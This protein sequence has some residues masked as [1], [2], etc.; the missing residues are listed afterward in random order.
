MSGIRGTFWADESDAG[1]CEVPHGNYHITN[2]V[3]LGQQKKL[4]SLIW[5]QGLCG[6]V[7][8]IDCGHGVIPAVVVSTC[9]LHSATCGV[10]M[11]RKT[12]NKATHNKKPRIVHCKVSLSKINPL[13]GK[14][15]VCYHRPNS[16]IGKKYSVIV[17]ILN[18]NGR[19]SKSATIRGIKG[20]R[21]NDGWFMF[22][23]GGK[24]LFDSSA[25][26]TFTF[27]NGGN[28]QI[29]LGDCKKGGS[30]QIFG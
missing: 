23:S 21:H 25:T 14:S 26:V 18:T 5:R 24:P 19:I 2:A 28:V 13:K 4:G 27:E 6:Q 20:V 12:W 10:D 29:K 11:I 3:A 7:L 16:E 1:G 15:M 30:T 17:G 22:N 8:N 9:N